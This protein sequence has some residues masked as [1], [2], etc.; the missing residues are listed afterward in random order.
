[1]RADHHHH[2]H[3]H[4]SAFRKNMEQTPIISIIGGM[5]DSSSGSDSQTSRSDFTGEGEGR[6]D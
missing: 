6:R 3:R 5:I 4:I 1:M 2:H